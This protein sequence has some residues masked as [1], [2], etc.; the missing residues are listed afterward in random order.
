MAIPEIPT[1]FMKPSTSLADPYPAPTIIPKWTLKDDSCDYESELA[2]VIGKKCKDVPEEAVLEYVLGYTAAND[3]SSRT[4]QFAQS[5][6]SYSK[7]FDGACPIG[8]VLVSTKS[9]PDPAKLK[10]RGLKNGRVM[11]NCGVE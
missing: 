5:Q 8:P 1:L 9:I 11:Q 3:V 10:M 2:I 6:W 4:S 7:G